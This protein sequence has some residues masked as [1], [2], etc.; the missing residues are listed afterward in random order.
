MKYSK[1]EIY[2]IFDSKSGYLQCGMQPSD[3]YNLEYKTSSLYFSESFLNIT[4][5]NFC[6]SLFTFLKKPS[7]F[8][9]YFAFPK[10]FF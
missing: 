10:Y 9:L 4:N 2:Y 5:I 6:I 3:F 7:K 1:Q 8:I